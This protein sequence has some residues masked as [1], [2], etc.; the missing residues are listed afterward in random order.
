M[1]IASP[2]RRGWCGGGNVFVRESLPPLHYLQLVIGEL[3]VTGNEPI[4]CFCSYS[5]RK[6]LYVE[7][8]NDTGRMI[9]FLRTGTR[10]VK[11]LEVP[12]A[13]RTNLTPSAG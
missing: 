11:K 6:S 13:S 10:M 12:A 4:Y 7:R 3:G 5:L 1:S 2:I 8:T 9:S